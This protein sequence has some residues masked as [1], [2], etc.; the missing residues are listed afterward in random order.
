MT[1][2]RSI[3]ARQLLSALMR[4]GWVVAWQTGSHRRL[5][6]PGWPND[7]FAFHD[8]QEIGSGCSRRLPRK[9]GCNR[10]ICRSAEKIAGF[11]GPLSIGVREM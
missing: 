5:K 3:K 1:R 7:T 11:P 2:W 6:R 4:I 10:T 8:N 9:Q